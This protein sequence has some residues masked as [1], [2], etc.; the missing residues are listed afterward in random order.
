[1]RA[2]LLS[3]VYVFGASFGVSVCCEISMSLMIPSHCYAQEICYHC[4]VPYSIV[5]FPQLTQALKALKG[6]LFFSFG[7]FLL[8]NPLLSIPYGL[9]KQICNP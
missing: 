9:G 7:S 1:M 8:N 5:Y 2:S 3:S 6:A 4:F